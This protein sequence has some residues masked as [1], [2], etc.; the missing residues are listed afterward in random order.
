M[1]LAVQFIATLF[2]SHPV[3]YIVASILGGQD[4]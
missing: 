1:S 4:P 2:E 3:L